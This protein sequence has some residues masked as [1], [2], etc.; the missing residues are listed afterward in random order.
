MVQIDMAFIDK[1]ERDKAKQ[2][3]QEAPRPQLEIDDRTRPLCDRVGHHWEI[4]NPMCV[5]CGLVSGPR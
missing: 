4:G 3:E 5:F 1:L 2:R